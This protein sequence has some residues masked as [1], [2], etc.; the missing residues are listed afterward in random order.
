M[1]REEKFFSRFFRIWLTILLREISIF[2]SPVCLS[3]LPESACKVEAS[4]RESTSSQA[5]GMSSAKQVGSHR[6][7][8]NESIEACFRLF[9]NR[10]KKRDE[11]WMRNIITFFH[12]GTKKIFLRKETGARARA[13]RDWMRYEICAASLDNCLCGVSK[14][15]KRA[16][17]KRNF[18]Q[19]FQFQSKSDVCL[20]FARSFEPTTMMPEKK[21]ASSRESFNL[22]LL[23]KISHS[24]FDHNSR[25]APS[26]RRM[27]KDSHSFNDFGRVDSLPI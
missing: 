20:I 23:Y 16:P 9:C 11:E 26:S 2:P 7:E 13:S 14:K 10:H 21:W 15:K 5:G 22:I 4:A 17:R 6:R 24:R 3:A 27:V 12:W 1:G 19:D 18:Q 25:A 8:K